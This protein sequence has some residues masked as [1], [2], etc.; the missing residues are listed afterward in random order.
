[1]CFTGSD[2]PKT[3]ENP[4]PN[5]IQF[6]LTLPDLRHVEIGIRVKLFHNATERA[7][8]GEHHYYDLHSL[9]AIR[10][11]NSVTFNFDCVGGTIWKLQKDYKRKRQQK[12]APLQRR[13][14]SVIEDG[15]GLK[16]WM[17]E[18]FQSKGLDVAIHCV[19]HK[20]EPYNKVI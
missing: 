19:C 16:S 12:A 15:W 6:L 3:D 2:S 18:G 5:L 10:T 17:K 1:M 4:I 7:Q 14:H 9:T 8:W 11:L 20:T 13:V